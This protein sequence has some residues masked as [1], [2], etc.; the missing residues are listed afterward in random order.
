VRPLHGRITRIS[1]ATAEHP[2][3]TQG[4]DEPAAPPERPDRFI[5]QATFENPDGDLKPG[6]LVRAKIYGRRAS[7]AARIVRVLS[8]WIKTIVW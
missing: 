8:R 6:S 4:L 1:P 7:Y 2:K 3:T 5:A